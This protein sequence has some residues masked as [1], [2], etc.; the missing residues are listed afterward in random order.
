[1]PTLHW[2]TRETDLKLSGLAPYRLLEAVDELSYGDL[3]TGN[4]LIQGDNL[5]AL[6]ALL[7]YYAGAVKCIYIDPPYNTRS[8]FE[9]YDDNLEHTQWLS[10]IYPRLELLRELLAEDGSVWISIDE[11]EA[12][13]LKVLCDEIFGRQNYLTTV[14]WQRKYSV[15][16]NFK[17]I[18]TICDYILVFSKSLNF[19]N[20]LLP[21][22]EES[23]ARYANPDNDP[24]GPWK[25]VDYLNQASPEKRKNL[26]YDI[27]NPNTGTVIKNTSKAWKYD[28][29]THR[30][31]VAENRIWWG[32]NGT[33]TA[34]ALKLFLAEVRDGMTPHN[35]WPHEEVGHTDESKKE[36]ISLYGSTNVFDTPK[37]E[38]LLHRI[39]QIATNEGDIVLDSFLGSGTT[40]A[41]AQKMGRRFIGI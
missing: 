20:N 37:P 35:W 17:G 36:M 5:D 21:R 10:M 18:A 16:N 33:N 8:A 3:S 22:T 12:H 1:M 23:A 34:P 6:K 41:V 39:M 32:R 30:K 40:A 9:H 11:R 24:R 31:H 28:P 26:C 13:Y 29:E 25:A 4:M 14:T 27:L 15:S 2:L 19:K 38:R 7:P